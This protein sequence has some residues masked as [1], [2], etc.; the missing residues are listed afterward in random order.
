MV[1]WIPA[2]F[3]KTARNSLKRLRTGWLGLWYT[4]GPADLL[5]ALRRVGVRTGDT[6]LVHISFDRFEV[7]TGK[8]S[9]VVTV[10]KDAVGP[11]GTLLMPTM[12]FTGSAIDYIADGTILD[13]KRTPSQMGLVTELFRRY[14]DV[15]RSAHPTHPVAGWGPRAAELLAD[16]HLTATP[17]GRTSPFGRLLDVGGKNLLL[18]A[19]IGTLTFFHTIEEILEPEMPFSAFT[20]ET[21]QLQC[22][23]ASG[24]LLQTQ[25][26]LFDKG[27]PKRRL[28]KLLPALKAN[29]AWHEEQVGRLPLILLRADEVLEACRA[30][31]RRGEF[32]YDR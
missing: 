27:V 15:R 1:R 13:V 2:R 7:F 26:R 11:E 18:G 10:L 22:R 17:C 24:T 32:C 14:P 21:F 8:A 31:A 20:R 4:F 25:T 29:G 6:L 23:D 12:P 3:R 9:D 28:S 30:M 5:A 16:H 19:P